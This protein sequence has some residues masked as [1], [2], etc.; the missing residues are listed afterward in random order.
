MALKALFESLGFI[1]IVFAACFVGGI[2]FCIVGSIIHGAV[3]AWHERRK[4]RRR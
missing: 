1:V 4:G 3:F 2:I